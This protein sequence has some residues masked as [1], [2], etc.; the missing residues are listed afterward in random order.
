MGMEVIIRGIQPADVPAV[1]QIQADSPDASCWLAQ[2]YERA[3]DGSFHGV[4]AVWGGLLAGFLVARLDEEE[5]EI[6]NLA[7]H[8]GLRRRGIATRL[9]GEVLHQARRRAAKNCFLEVRHTNAAGIELY[10]RHGFRQV[11]RR[12]GYYSDP[13]AD[14]IL[15]RLSL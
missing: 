13:P 8:T 12:P 14:A 7:V 6:L 4:V 15:F 9:L 1:L 10:L 3:C 5:V 11:G 2:D